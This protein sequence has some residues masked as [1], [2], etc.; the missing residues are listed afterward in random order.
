MQSVLGLAGLA[1]TV[2]SIS[3]SDNLAALQSAVKS[4]AGMLGYDRFVLYSATPTRDGVLDQLFWVEGGWFGDGA[5]VNAETYLRRCPITRHVLETD[6]PFFW[7]KRRVGSEETY[8]VVKSPH[9]RGVHGLQVPVFGI[10]GLKGAMSFGG[11]KIDV[12]LATVL[13][14]TL[15]AEASLRAALA[16]H[17]SPADRVR[18]HSLSEREKQILRQ[19]ASGQR[20]GDIARQLVLSERTIENHLRRVRKRL[21][22]STTAQAILTAI[23]LGEIDVAPD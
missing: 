23:R 7:T 5:D 13:A 15:V 11:S 21:G 1:E 14:L 8:R 20:Q 12:S 10:G 4:H 2:E 17:G 18:P 6:S 19:I 3:R 22:V 9:G 16:L